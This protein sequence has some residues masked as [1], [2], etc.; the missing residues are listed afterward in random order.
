M[1]YTDM[2]SDIIARGE[3]KA[4]EFKQDVP[5]DIMRYVP[6]ATAFANT[7]GGVIVFGISDTG[8]VV[9]IDESQ[10]ESRIEEISYEIGSRTEPTI[11]YEIDRYCLDGKHLIVAEIHRGSMTPYKV[12]GKGVFIRQGRNTFQ[13]C[14]ERVRELELERINRSFDSLPFYDSAGRRD[15]DPSDVDRLISMLGNPGDRTVTEGT[16]VSMGLLN[17]VD[18]RP[19]STVAFD[20]L[21][22]N[23][24]GYGLS[25]ALFRGMDKIDFEDRVECS[26]NI[27]EQIETA[28][29]FVRRNMRCRAV[30]KGLYREDVY[31]VPLV[32]LREAIVNALVHRSYVSRDT[33]TVTILD[34]RIEV[35]SPGSLLVRSEQ[36]GSGLY[37]TRNEVIARFLRDAG[38]CEVRGTGIPRMREACSAQG[39]R[40]PLIE[41][42]EDHVRVTFF[43]ESSRDRIPAL[44]MHERRMLE[45]MSKE[46]G[47][48]QGDLAEMLGVSKAYVA[49][50][51]RYSKDRG[52]LVRDETVRKGGWSVDLDLL[53]RL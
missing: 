18:G 32:A 26:G 34:D 24:G 33:V 36:L 14:E 8:E 31:D 3:G 10:V 38:V 35:E 41:E 7:M 46:P 12:K 17:D 6:T 47:I 19:A 29:A 21:T 50:M 40:E 27:M 51:I 45:I 1:R 44:G 53:G 37:R 25:C 28:V 39:L 2:L 23:R 30:I 43:K 15:V 22:V 5:K 42:I 16:L 48:S 9:G 4:V 11:S 13:A 49:K 20:L 52:V